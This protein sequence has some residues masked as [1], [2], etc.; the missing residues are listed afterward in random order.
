MNIAR[1]VSAI[2]LIVLPNYSALAGNLLPQHSTTNSQGQAGNTDYTG[3]PFG[4]SIYST[5]WGAVNAQLTDAGYAPA[6]LFWYAGSFFNDRSSMIN[7]RAA[8]RQIAAGGVVPSG[9]AQRWED[10]F[11]IS[12]PASDF[13]AEPAYIVS[14]RANGGNTPF[15]AMPEFRAWVAWEKA[16]PNLQAV[17][18]DGGT[19]GQDFRPWGGTWGLITPMMPLSPADCPPDMKS[20][21]YGDWYAYR[22]AQTSHFSGAYGLVLSDFANSLPGQPSWTEDFNPAIVESFTAKAGIT[23]KSKITQQASAYIV[24]TALPLWNDYICQGYA[25]F[26]NA[27]ATRIS[28]STGKQALVV[29]GAFDWPGLNRSW[30]VDERMM[31]AQR[32]LAANLLVVSDNITIE[33][34]RDGDNITQGIAG[35]VINAAREPGIRNGAYLSANDTDF[36]NAVAKF[37]PTLSAAD[38]QEWGLKQLKRQWLEYAWA[39]VAGFNGGVRRAL[40]F[41]WRDHADAGT[42]DPATTTLIQT[43]RPVRPFGF[44]L[45]Y[46]VAVERAVEPFVPRTLNAYLSPNALLAFRQAV[47]LNY[48]VSDASLPHLRAKSAPA[49]WIVLEAGDKL[50]AAELA[51]LT[52]IAPVLTS[53]KQALA[54]AN[55]P[56][57]FTGGLTGTGFIDQLD[58]IIITATNPSTA[59]NAGTISGSI[60][61]RGLRDGTYTL[62]DLYAGTKTPV[63]VSGTTATIPVSVT[64]WDTLAFA[65]AH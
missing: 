9:T 34:D 40:A 20:C 25:A 56:L 30:G 53:A 19:M 11:E 10:T 12:Q 52:K 57:A 32:G 44:A 5:S 61:V 36:W 31:M 51:S 23:L 39:H 49:A 33:M 22:W 18:N 41:A 2:Y 43:I 21:T 13:G 16:R 47:P 24:D 46:S 26:F 14:D 62:T 38:Q 28:A 37:N 48:Y 45:Y 7:A 15:D 27:L 65:L 54:F 4:S 50:P 1:L 17:A 3:F 35:S 58:R 42:V 6:N 55:A 29:A 60:I 59:A 64:R 8:A 63:T